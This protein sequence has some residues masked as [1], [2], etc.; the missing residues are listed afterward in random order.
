MLGLLSGTTSGLVKKNGL[1][2]LCMLIL[3]FLFSL[4]SNI[5][6]FSVVSIF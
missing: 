5:Q 1:E 6:G 4:A 2:F 3:L